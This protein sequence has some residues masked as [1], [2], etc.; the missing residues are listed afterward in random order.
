RV[1]FTRAYSLSAALQYNGPPCPGAVPILHRRPVPKS[2][3]L[4]PVVFPTAELHSVRRFSGSR[5]RCIVLPTTPAKERST[6]V[7]PEL[8]PNHRSPV[9]RWRGIYGGASFAFRGQ[10][11]AIHDDGICPDFTRRVDLWRHYQLTSTRLTERHRPDS[12]S[13][14]TA[15]RI[16]DRG[17]SGCRRCFVAGQRPSGSANVG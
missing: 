1:A 11:A 7:L 9:A 17:R 15:H 16:G 2:P 13:Q 12:G 10:A 4:P 6:P 5:Y 8:T 3:P 14:S